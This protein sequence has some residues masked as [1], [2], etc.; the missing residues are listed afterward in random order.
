MDMPGW[1][2][3]RKYRLAASVRASDA[4][5]VE[6]MLVDLRWQPYRIA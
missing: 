3:T 2:P 1:T 5:A 4:E 6:L